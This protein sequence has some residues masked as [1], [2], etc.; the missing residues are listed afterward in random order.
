M[1]EQ[2]KTMA[3]VPIRVKS[4]FL[5]VFFFDLMRIAVIAIAP[6]ISGQMLKHIAEDTNLVIS[7]RE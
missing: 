3:P 2:T 4:I 7:I 5:P 1:K 6:N